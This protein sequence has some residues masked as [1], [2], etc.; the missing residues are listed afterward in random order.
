MGGVALICGFIA[1]VCTSRYVSR[2]NRK[3][4]EEAMHIADE[5]ARKRK[6][7]NRQTSVSK[8]IKGEKHT[9]KR[10]KKKK[11][12]K[13]TISTSSSRGPLPP[14]DPVKEEERAKKSS[15]GQLNSIQTDYMDETYDVTTPGYHEKQVQNAPSGGIATKRT[16]SSHDYKSDITPTDDDSPIYHVKRATSPDGKL[17]RGSDHG[18]MKQRQLSTTPVGQT[19]KHGV[20]VHRSSLMYEPTRSITPT[21]GTI[22]RIESELE[23]DSGSTIELRAMTS[24]TGTYARR[25]IIETSVLDHPSESSSGIG[26]SLMTI[27]TQTNSVPPREGVVIEEPDDDALA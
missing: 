25:V 10:K 18:I 8:D 6:Q 12:R 16:C 23:S 19:G 15:D 5:K 9:V 11:K 22:I 17:L 7:N 24:V 3:D 1:C 2:A 14:L 21:D 20:Q 13:R 27:D 26:S 4:T